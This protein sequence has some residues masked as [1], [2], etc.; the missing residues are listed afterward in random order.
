MARFGAIRRVLFITLA[1]NL[2]ATLAKMVVGYMTGSLSIV[3]DGFDSLFDSASNLIGLVG[4]SFAA[5]PPDEE[6]P[7]GHRKFETL[8]AIS[9]SVLLFVTCVELARSVIH[10]LSSPAVPRINLWSFA[11]VIFSIGVHLFTVVYER[12]GVGN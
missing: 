2:L 4:I 10:R 1:L 12:V 11:A 5:H 9:V 8:A 6:H 7:Y 3:A